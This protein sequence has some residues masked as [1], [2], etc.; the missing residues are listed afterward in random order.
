[1]GALGRAWQKPRGLL[2]DV[3]PAAIYL[4]VLFWFGLT[5]LKSLPGKAL[6]SLRPPGGVF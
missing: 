3:G 4:V 2:L 6:N 5:P 1:M